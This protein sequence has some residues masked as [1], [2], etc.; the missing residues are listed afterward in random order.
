MEKDN[1]YNLKDFTKKA[2]IAGGILAFILIL[3][4]LF[5]ATFNVLLLILAGTL[6][7]VFFRGFSGLIKRKTKWKTGTSLIISVTISLLFLIL[8]FWLMGSKLA[9]QVT[10]FNESFPTTIE[11]AKQQ[12]N[13]TEIGK[14]VVQ[15]LSSEKT[16]KKLTSVAQT[17]FKT[18]FGV[19]GDIYVILFIGLFFTV[20]PGV[21]KKG[22]VKLVP[23]A[24]KH[25][26]EDILEKMA[27]NLEKWL[28]GKLF[29]MLVVFVLTA[30]GLLI[31]GVPMWLVLALIAGI[32]NFIP[33]FGPLI[34]LIPA[35]LVALLQ[36]PSTAAWVAG[37]YIFVQIAE[38]NFITPMVQQ[39][40]INIPPALIIIAQLMIAP[41]SGGW[42][43][44]VA[45]PLMILII[46]LVQELY[47]KKQ[48]A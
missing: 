4:L 7:A 44:V 28:K 1:A 42:G 15:K 14:Q 33:N 24:G 41:L 39:K 38:S 37:L 2:W 36:G 40:L 32:L 13:K 18:S 21:Y 30:T 25:T 31:I 27:G 47:I 26:A 10:Q 23:A 6:I 45:T 19:L 46:V 9:T 20:S 11:N 43:L 8:I 5:K 3:L 34:A 12:L 22:L 35:V 29:A 17:F 48:Q 16:H